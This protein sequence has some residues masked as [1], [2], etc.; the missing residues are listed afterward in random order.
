MI[1]I[2]HHLALISKQK[3]TEL[4][5]WKNIKSNLFNILQLFSIN[6]SLNDYY[7]IRITLPPAGVGLNSNYDVIL[8]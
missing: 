7:P 1:L 5:S 3:F 2:L 4:R 6:S 8:T